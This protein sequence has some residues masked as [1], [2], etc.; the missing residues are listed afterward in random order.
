M[1]AYS[2]QYIKLRKAGWAEIRRS[3]ALLVVF[4]NFALFLATSLPSLLD[5]LCSL[6]LLLVLADLL[7]YLVIGC[8][9]SLLERNSRIEDVNFSRKIKLAL[10]LLLGVAV[11]NACVIFNKTHSNWHKRISRKI[12]CVLLKITQALTTAT[13]SN[14]SKANFWYHLTL[15][16]KTEA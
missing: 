16:C 8:R 3:T 14:S 9:V 6:H 1:F 13:P 4:I 10:E 15:F 12:E 2:I 11:V 7:C 5:S